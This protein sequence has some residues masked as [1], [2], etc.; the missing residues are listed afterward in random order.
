MLC[1]YKLCMYKYNIHMYTF[2]IIYIYMVYVRVCMSLSRK[3]FTAEALTDK[4]RTNRI[5]ACI[6]S[7]RR[8]ELCY[9]RLAVPLEEAGSSWFLAKP[10]E[11]R[12]WGHNSPQHPTT[13]P[14]QPMKAIFII[15]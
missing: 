11:A 10:H 13:S 2:Y 15:P 9:A 4:I 12:D 3:R 1:I 8:R 6:D 7:G 14:P 5:P